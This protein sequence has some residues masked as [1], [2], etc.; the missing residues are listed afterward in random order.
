MGVTDVCLRRKHKTHR[1]PPKRPVGVTPVYHDAIMQQGSQGLLF[2]DWI[3]SRGYT[4]IES[5]EAT[6]NA[7]AQCGSWGSG[8]LPQETVEAGQSRQTP[9]SDWPRAGAGLFFCLPKNNSC[10]SGPPGLYR[11]HRY[12]VKHTEPPEGGRI[13]LLSGSAPAPLLRLAPPAAAL[14]PPVTL[15]PAARKPCPGSLFYTVP[16]KKYLTFYTV[17]V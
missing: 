7:S 4:L 10:G 17:L 9:V 2:I 5:L 16:V 13:F 15:A 6:P 1:E 14:R 11:Q 3:S 12:Q 8:D